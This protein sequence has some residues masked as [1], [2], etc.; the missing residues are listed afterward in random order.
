MHFRNMP[1]TPTCAV[2]TYV[3]GMACCTDGDVL[4]DA[5]GHGVMMGWETPLMRLHAERLCA[6]GGD[7]LNV[8][9]GMGII[10][11]F[12]GEIGS[13]SHTIVEAHPMVFAKMERDG[14][15]DKRGVRCF[16]GRW[17]DVL[18]TLPDGSFDAKVHFHDRVG[19]KRKNILSLHQSVER[20]GNAQALE[21]F[22]SP[23]NYPGQFFCGRRA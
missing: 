3:G 6:S 21:F 20:D 10:D 17:Q 22:Q 15:T 11:G 9:F 8:G 5:G 12:I 18:P 4:L 1:S 14:W 7:V 13:R 16:L 23:V 19:S 2:A